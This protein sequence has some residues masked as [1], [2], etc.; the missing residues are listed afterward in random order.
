MPSNQ[1]RA[2]NKKLSQIFRMRGLSV[3]PDAMQVLYDKLESD[4]NWEATLQSLLAEL[5]QQKLENGHVDSA[6]VQAALSAVSSRQAEHAGLG[7]EVVDAFGMPGLRYDAAR[8][9]FTASGVPPSM[10]ADA[11]AKTTMFRLRLSLVE[12]RLRRNAMFKAPVLAHGVEHKAHLQLTSIDA[13]LGR[14]G[15]RVILGM[16]SELEEGRFFLEDTNAA[17]ELDL[18]AAACTAG[19]FTRQAVVLAEGEVQPDGRFRVSQLGLPPPESRALTLESLGPL[20][21][22]RPSGAP[23][24][25]NVSEAA[26]ANAMLVVLSDV[27]LDQPATLEKLS[28][29]FGGYESVGAQ[30]VRCGRQTKPLASF[31][32]F[33]LCGNFTSPALTAGTVRRS[34]LTALFGELGAIVGRCKTL[35]QHAQFVLVPGPADA[36][37]TSNEVLPRGHVPE[38]MCAELR[39]RVANVELT[40]SPARLRLCGQTVVVFREDL[41]L[42][43]RRSCILP[44]A[45]D[46][47]TS[48]LNGHLVKTIVDQA[49]LCPLPLNEAAVAWQ[50]DHA[51]WLHPAPDVLVLADRHNQYSHTYHETLAFNPGTFVSDA[52]WMVYRPGTREV[53]ASALE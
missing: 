41:L 24:E 7:L 51:L 38:S 6:A 3:R 50:H 27:H 23:A 36:T 30:T 13:L 43:A 5:Q 48:D 14:S 42:K 4:E 26:L 11:E 40:S 45:D 1:T 28:V 10:Y 47:T 35:S 39:K 29:L 44:P 52:S 53:E 8:K 34:T 17:I 2:L 12:Q 46:E 9:A 33:V 31:F 49:H 37:V 15:V 32:T 19:L 21:P 18:S 20:D 22:L 25:P 16:V